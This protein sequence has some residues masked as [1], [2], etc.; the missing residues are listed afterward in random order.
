VDRAEELRS[1][2]QA[3]NSQDGLPQVSTVR[4]I[5]T[6]TDAPFIFCIV[7]CGCCR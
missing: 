5:N 4:L 3:E 2:D 7:L 1:R 6:L